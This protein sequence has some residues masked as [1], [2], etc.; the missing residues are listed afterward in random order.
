MNRKINANGVLFTYSH[1]SRFLIPAVLSC[2]VSAVVQAC[3]VSVNGSHTSNRLSG[4]TA[5]QQGGWQIVGMLI[6]IATA[7]LAGLIV[8]ILIKLINKNTTD[9]QFNDQFTYD[10]VPSPYIQTD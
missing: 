6:T 8:G 7:G 9:D 10:N 2:I 4:R 5:I 1:I 3:D